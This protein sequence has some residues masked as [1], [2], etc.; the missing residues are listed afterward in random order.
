MSNDQNFSYE[1]LMKRIR[2]EGNIDES[3]IAQI[4]LGALYYW[5]L[6]RGE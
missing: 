6:K 4:I 1:E 3:D 2:E 5:W